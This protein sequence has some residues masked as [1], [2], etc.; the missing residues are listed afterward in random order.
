MRTILFRGI[1]RGGVMRYGHLCVW[2]S[3]L[4]IQEVTEY[5]PTQEEPCGGTH[6][7]YYPINPET[8]GQLCGLKDRNGVEI[9]FGD[10]V[11]FADKREWY[12]IQYTGE[13]MFAKTPEEYSAVLAQMDAEPY[14]VREVSAIKDYEWLLSSEIQTYWEVCGN[15]HENP[16][17]LEAKP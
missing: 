11:R 1:D 10:I 9:Y 6:T 5:G 15:I 13:L 16:E 17:L 12:R 3:S 2:A 14:E 4:C 8:V 7:E